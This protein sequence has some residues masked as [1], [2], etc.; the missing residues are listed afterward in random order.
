MKKPILFA[1]VAAWLA[2]PALAG[3][4]D[5]N[6]TANP[7]STQ[8]NAKSAP[9]DIQPGSNADKRDD[10]KKGLGRHTD[11][12]NKGCIGGNPP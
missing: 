9:Q 12:C 10:A 1:I 6:Q 7:S 11:D 8:Q 4:N 2:V 3:T 5:V